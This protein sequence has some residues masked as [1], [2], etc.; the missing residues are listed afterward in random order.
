MS[1]NPGAVYWADIFHID[2]LWNCNVGL[3]RVKINEKEA[4]VGTLKK[5]CQVWQL[6]DKLL[7]TPESRSLNPVITKFYI[8]TINCIEMTKINEEA[9][10]GP[11]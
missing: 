7:A 8:P 2:L 1:S 11:I 5:F 3:K 9:G 10:N 6:V 4:G